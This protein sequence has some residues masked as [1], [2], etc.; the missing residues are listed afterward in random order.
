VHPLAIRV[1]DEV[2]INLRS[3][4]S[5]TL[6]PFLDNRWDYVITVCDSAGER[7]P[8][9][10]GPVQ[11]IHWSFEDPGAARGTEDERLRTFR[12]VRAEIVGR[13]RAWLADQRV[14]A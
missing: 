1:M 9:F 7:C 5:K 2:G 11:Q 12:R 4:S 10:P 3:H 6:E 13:I 8:V 14:P